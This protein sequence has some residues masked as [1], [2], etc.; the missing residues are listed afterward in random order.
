MSKVTIEDI[1]RQTGLSR[2]TVSRALNNRPDISEQT[3]QRVLEACRKLNYVPSYAARSLATGRSFAV[4]VL[5]SDV[6]SAFSASFLRGLIERADPAGYVVHVMD[7]GTTHEAAAAQIRAFSSERVDGVVIGSPLL[8]LEAELAHVLAGHPTA[9]C[10]PVPGISADVFLPD[11]VE[12]GRL[13]ARHLIR[14]GRRDLC[15]VHAPGVASAEERWSGFAEVCAQEGL[16]A[17]SFRLDASHADW[18]GDLARRLPQ[19]R[20]VAA[21]DDA[22]AISAMFVCF[23]AGRIPG[24]DV[25]VIGQG[26]EPL[27]A[28][29]QP[30]LT[31]VDFS[32]REIGRRSFEVLLQRLDQSR[33]DTPH[34]VTVAPQ[35]VV[36]ETSDRSA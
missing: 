16:D 33:M 23:Q 6:E 12:A 8:N 22:H 32:G 3:K 28:A 36:R 35:L 21:T 15:Y 18:R 7:V 17:G 20:G 2:G 4:A 29:V 31:T 24:R 26:N 34:T 10:V 19:V 11:Q 5:L 25:A 9:A 14:G 1:S 13:A 27:G 30:A